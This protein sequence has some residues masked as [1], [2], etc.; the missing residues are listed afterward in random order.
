[1]EGILQP[2]PLAG[3]SRLQCTG[4]ETETYRGGDLP[5]IM[6]LVTAELGEDFPP[7]YTVPQFGPKVEIF[8]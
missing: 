4:G 1:M 3:L 8:Y 2:T 7:Q 5:K 6:Q